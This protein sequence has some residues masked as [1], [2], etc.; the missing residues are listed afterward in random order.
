MAA[1][2]VPGCSLKKF[3]QEHFSVVIESWFEGGV[4]FKLLHPG[5]CP[6]FVLKPYRGESSPSLLP[7]F[8]ARK[9]ELLGCH[10]EM[11]G[12]QAQAPQ[13]GL[14]HVSQL[15]AFKHSL[16]LPSAQ[17]RS[18]AEEGGPNCAAGSSAVQTRRLWQTSTYLFHVLKMQR[19]AKCV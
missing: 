15:T 13:P 18:T 12:G 5:S 1:W 2:S 9:P 11:Y 14:Q 8:H 4:G 17:K 16:P 3:E 10:R 7:Y 19:H 6:H